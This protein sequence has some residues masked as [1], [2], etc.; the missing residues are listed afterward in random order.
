MT[1]DERVMLVAR[2]A[3]HRCAALA[4]PR[5]GPD[6]LVAAALRLR[7]DGVLM[8][9]DCLGRCH[10]GAV[11]AVGWAHTDGKR[12]CWERPPAVVD[13]VETEDAARALAAWLEGGCNE[14]SAPKD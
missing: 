8:S 7:R 13:Q 5:T 10:A 1:A 6:D 3:G 11:A 14:V 9:T 4:R 2:C 12:L